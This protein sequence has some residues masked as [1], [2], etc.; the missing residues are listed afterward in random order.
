MGQM[1]NRYHITD[2]GKVFRVN[3]DG[4]FSE[5]GDVNKL[6]SK[7]SINAGNI[8]EKPNDYF[9]FLIPLVFPLVVLMIFDISAVIPIVVLVL[10]ALSNAY[11]VNKYWKQGE[12]D[13]AIQASKSAK[14]WSVVANVLGTALGIMVILKQ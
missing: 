10:I 6:Q 14:G 9:K 3:E 1:P 7:Q 13:K 12:Y 11:K 5:I 4:S 2:D 8:P